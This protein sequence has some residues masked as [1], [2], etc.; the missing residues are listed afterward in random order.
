MDVEIL[1]ED[2]RWE[3]AEL[4]GLADRAGRAVSECLGLPETE[5]A[6]LAADDARM[7]T[8]NAA[9]RGREAPTNVLSWPAQAV[10]PPT[11]PAADFPGEPVFLGDLALG[12]ET[13]VAESQAGGIPLSAH[14]TH[15]IVHGILHL[16]GYDH[17]TEAEAAVMED[18]E[19][20]ILAELGLENPYC[21]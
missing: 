18:L 19:A 14:V 13:C 6:L 21:R 4:A 9:H 5:V 16:L 20:E 11:L 7:T 12:Y 10:T 3:A 8:L 17:G 2:P 1:A 15:L